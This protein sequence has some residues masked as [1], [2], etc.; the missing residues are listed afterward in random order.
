M[1]Q[2]FVAFGILILLF[3]IS[4]AVVTFA[5]YLFPS[6]DQFIPEPWQ[7]WLTFRYVSY[8]VLAASLCLWIGTL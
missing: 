2:L 6:I 8:F 5:R 1:S 4:A 7:Q 3:A